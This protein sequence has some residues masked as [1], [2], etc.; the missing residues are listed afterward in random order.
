PRAGHDPYRA[1]PRRRLRQ[2]GG[3][4]AVVLGAPDRGPAGDLRH[5]DR[6]RRLRTDGEGDSQRLTVE[7]WLPGPVGSGHGV[8]WV[9]RRARPL[10]RGGTIV[11]L[12]R[13]T[14]LSLTLV[15]ACVASLALTQ[16]AGA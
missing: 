8:H 3:R 2:A 13:R 6:V 10:Y 11:L 15:F 1:R 9:S 4:A 14:A 16:M 7:L 5:R 12:S